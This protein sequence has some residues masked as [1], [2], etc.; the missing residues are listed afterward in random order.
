MLTVAYLTFRENPRFEW[1][2]RSLYREIN[3]MPDLSALGGLQIVIIDGR[4]WK[5]GPVRGAAMKEAAAGLFEFEHWAPKPSMWQGPGRVTS[6]DFFAAASSR[7]TAFCAARGTHVAFVDDLSVLLPGWLRAH[8]HAMTNGY[9]LAGTTCKHNDIVVNANG[10]VTSF[11]PHPPGFDSR[12]KHLSA[13]L[14][15]CG[16]EWLYGG[17]FSVP[18]EAAL[19]VNGQD[20]MHDSIGG[21]DYDFGIRLKRAG[22]AIKITPTCGTFEDEM[23]HHREAAMVRLDKPWSGPLGPFTSNLLLN[24]LIADKERFI[25]TGNRFLLRELRDLILAGE[26][27]PTGPWPERHWVDSQPMSEL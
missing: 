11:T 14:Q 5:D 2:A 27:F 10:D 8:V 23:A 17:T 24:N 18:L 21:E 3:S 13:G 7:N 26:S 4:L 22:Y 6:R 19:I 9:V 20:E 15:D 16:G 12:I 25:T 1:F